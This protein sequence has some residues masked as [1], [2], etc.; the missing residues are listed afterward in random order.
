MTPK[1]A[2]SVFTVQTYLPAIKGQLHEHSYPVVES[3]SN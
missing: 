3:N 1:L 2:I